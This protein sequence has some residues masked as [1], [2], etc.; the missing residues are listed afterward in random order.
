MRLPDID[1]DFA[2]RKEI[3]SFLPVV[4]AMILR[5]GKPSAHPSGVYLQ[6]APVDPF[7]GLA[8][9]DTHVMEDR[10]FFKLDFLNQTV[11]REIRDEQHLDTLLAMEPLWELLDEPAM[12]EQLPHVYNHYD[13]LQEIQPRSIDDL[14]VVLA[15]VRP[16]KKHLRGRSRAEIDAEIWT[17]DEANQFIFKRA[18]AI[19]YATLV[20]I[21]LNLI[22]EEMLRAV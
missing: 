9:L 8:S 7:T 16:G 17:K 19:S 5:D 6:D 21:K 22:V 13:V 18:H 1:I 11:Y 20:M 4:P 10:G 12:V 14:S 2:D 15:L 3:M